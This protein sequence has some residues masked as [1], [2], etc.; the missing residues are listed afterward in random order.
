[1]K[2]YK[3]LIVLFSLSL[4]PSVQ[5][6]QNLSLSEAISIGLENNY[7]LKIIRYDEEIS[8]INNHWGNTGAFPKIDFTLSGLE[9]FNL[10]ENSR[11]QTLSPEVSLS[12]VVFN[13][14][15]A[16]IAKQKYEELEKQSQ[17]NTSILIESSIQDIILAY[18]NCL[19]QQQ[20]LEVYKEL[21]NLSEDRFNRSE[22]SR[23]IGAS[24]TYNSLQ[25][26]TAWLEDQSNYLQQKVNY[27]NAIRTLNYLLGVNNDSRWT[28]TSEMEINLPNYKIEDMNAKLL[29][30]NKT[31]K[32]QYIYQSLLAK[33]TSLAKNSFYPSVS[34]SSGLG[35]DWVDKYT[36]ATHQ[37]STSTYVGLNVSFNIFNGGSKKRSL[38]IAKINEESAQVET[39]QMKH[40]LSNQLLQLHSNYEVQKAL[41]N[42]AEQNEEAAKLNLNLSSEKLKNGAI[43]SFNF[44][45]VQ[46]SYMNS[47]IK[48]LQAI[49]KLIESNTDLLRITGGIINEYE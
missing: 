10:T 13:G 9:K 47:A 15:S 37:K 18:H 14:F 7:D 46:I 5:A 23:K 35:Q 22:N 11:T 49:Y 8:S 28:L 39:D 16:K 48:K 33:E 34:L 1:M 4:L 41:L 44:R 12:W 42:L 36:P 31:L 40:S 32:N 17:G 19:I 20:M 6:Q 27:E 24:T 29:S 3:L 25:T 2:I 43:N 30:N 45:D 21:A 26:K 38:Q